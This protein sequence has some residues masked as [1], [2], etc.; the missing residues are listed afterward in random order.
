MAGKLVTGSYAVKG[1]PKS[2]SYSG[3]FVLTFNLPDKFPA[4]PRAGGLRGAIKTGR[5]GGPVVRPAL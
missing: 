4:K 2:V 3:T 1:I 5:L